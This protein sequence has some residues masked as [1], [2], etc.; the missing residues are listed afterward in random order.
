[1][2]HGTALFC[3]AAS[4]HFGGFMFFRSTHN[5]ALACMMTALICFGSVYNVFAMWFCVQFFMFLIFVKRLEF[6]LLALNK[7]CIII[8]II[9]IG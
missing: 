7:L 4:C 6:L 1:M 9:I 5:N 2:V 3:S 8:I